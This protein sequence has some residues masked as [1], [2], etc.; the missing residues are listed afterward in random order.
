[1]PHTKKK[2][3]KGKDPNNK[4][5]GCYQ[6]SWTNNTARKKKKTPIA[7]CKGED[8]ISRCRQN[9]PPAKPSRPP[10]NSPA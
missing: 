1:M 3:I 5:A 7:V 10:K 4:V 8:S 6:E 2:Q 9:K